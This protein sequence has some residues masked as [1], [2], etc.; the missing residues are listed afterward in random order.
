MPGIVTVTFSPCIDRS[1]AVPTLVPEKKLNC[2]RQKLEPGGGGINVARAI[3]KLGGDVVA[4]YPAGGYTGM[5]FNKLLSE[6]NIPA[7]IVETQ[8]ETRE[9][10]II[11]D[12]T[13]TYYYNKV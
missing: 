2:V 11:L 3:R 7:I 1:A 10:V 8:E 4:I 13:M 6:E 5:H 12:G 9:N